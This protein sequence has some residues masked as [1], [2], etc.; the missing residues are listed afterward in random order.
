M[1]LK[2]VSQYFKNNVVLLTTQ[3]SQSYK[4]LTNS[5]LCF[6]GETRLNW[7]DWLDG[8]LWS[9]SRSV[10]CWC[11]KPSCLDVSAVDDESRTSGTAWGEVR[12]GA[13]V[14]HSC[15]PV[16]VHSVTTRWRTP[17]SFPRFPSILLPAVKEVGDG[18]SQDSRSLNASLTQRLGCDE[19]N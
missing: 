9:E 14:C 11:V 8:D 10:Y 4:T 13:S 1:Y 3:L 12:G 6:T 17:L 5:S 16:V 18:R 15:S 2:Y 7:M 19:D